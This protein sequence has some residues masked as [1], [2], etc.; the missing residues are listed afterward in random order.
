MNFSGQRIL[1]MG[2]GIQGGGVG[3]ARFFAEKGAK[4]K[5]TDLKT[6][7]ELKTSLDLLRDLPITY[8]LGKHREEDFINSDLVIRNPDVSKDS[9]SL[10][11]ARKHHVP[12][13]MDESLFFKLCPH[14]KNIIGVTGT[15][16]KTTTTH[17]IG[18]ILEASGYKTLLGGN[19][20]GV[21]TLS[22]LDKMT[23]QTKV[24]LELSSWQLQGL[25]EDKISP[26]LAVL[27]NIYP[28]HLN[29]YQNMEAYLQ[30]KKIIFK[31]QEENDFLVLNFENKT[32]LD[33]AREAKSKRVFFKKSDLP[34]SLVS[35]LK[36]KGEHNL[37][38][39]A[40]AYQV[41]KVLEIDQ[42]ITEKAL[43]GF[44][45]VPFRLEE[46][47]SLGGVTFVN[48]T[49]STTPIATIKALK[50]YQDKKIILL[51]GGSSKNLDLKELA[52]EISR[53]AKAVIFLE[54]TATD[55][56]LSEVKRQKSKIK[57]LGKFD[58]LQKAVIQAKMTAEPGDYV[59]LSPGCAS[60]GMFKNEFDRGEQFN[61]VVF[62]I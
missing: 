39:V 25:D 62:S 53:R 9:P 11:V 17:L 35:Q 3:V 37:E 15:R 26:H 57:I 43:M 32:C 22:L 56:L 8:I 18:K 49:T 45:G 33:L 46:I 20:R 38:N 34:K 14:R 36:L 12:V 60:F 40:A 6:A 5:V 42:R 1:V 54:G 4:V 47:R 23:P 52:G 16:G 31:Y 48:D 29:R 58:D 2:L 19:L 7:K 30:D 55:E 27:T 13:E 28:D 24:V 51:A 41:A 50:A 10:A 61:H 59:I 44:P 21:A